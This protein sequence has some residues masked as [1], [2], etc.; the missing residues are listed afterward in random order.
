MNKYLSKKKRL[1][2]AI[3]FGQT[4]ANNLFK[5]FGPQGNPAYK[6]INFKYPET[7]INMVENLTK[8]HISLYPIK[9][10]QL[11]ATA[12]ESA[13]QEIRKLIDEHAND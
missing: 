3:D 8:L 11:M 4:I 1:E 2:W 12:I 6:G 5:E 9:N 7:L 13:K 10:E